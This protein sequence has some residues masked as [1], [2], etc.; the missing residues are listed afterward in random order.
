MPTSN[1]KHAPVGP[2]RQSSYPLLFPQNSDCWSPNSQG[3]SLHD[4]AHA[5][6]R[7]SP[8]GPNA[9]T[10]T[11]PTPACPRSQAVSSTG[12]KQTIESVCGRPIDGAKAVL[13]RPP[14]PGRASIN[15]RGRSFAGVS[16]KRLAPT[17]CGSRGQETETILGGG[18]PDP[19]VN[20]PPCQNNSPAKRS[21]GRTEIT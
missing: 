10:V 3:G 11:M 1:Y 14:R 8:R 4:D 12:G 7:D 9:A 13:Q 16:A 2:P 15:S 17:D 5:P 19:P 18:V 20:Q 6:C 21:L